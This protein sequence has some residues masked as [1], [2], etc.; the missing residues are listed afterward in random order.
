MAGEDIPWRDTRETEIR[1]KKAP[2]GSSRG[3]EAQAQKAEEE[4]GFC[5]VSKIRKVVLLKGK[6]VNGT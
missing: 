3:G 6:R 1:E 4:L 2:R 5:N